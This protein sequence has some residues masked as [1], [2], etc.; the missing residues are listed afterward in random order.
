MPGAN[1]KH[2]PV[3][4]PSHDALQLSGDDAMVLCGLVTVVGEFR[5]VNEALPCRP[6]AQ[7][8]RRGLN[9]VGQ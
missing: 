6:A 2:E 8:F 7:Q 1:E 4:F 9:V 5:E 3:D